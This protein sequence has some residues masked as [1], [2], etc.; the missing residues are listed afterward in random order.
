M[1][2]FEAYIPASPEREA[3][4]QQILAETIAK[5]NGSDDN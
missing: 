2:D 1:D 4:N 5:L 3:R